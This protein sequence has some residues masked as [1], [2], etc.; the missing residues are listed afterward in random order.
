MSAVSEPSLTPLLRGAWPEFA[1]TKL[2]HPR[3]LYPQRATI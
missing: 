3:D 1:S 2:T